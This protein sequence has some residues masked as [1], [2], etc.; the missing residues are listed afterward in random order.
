MDRTIDW[1]VLWGELVDLSRRRQQKRAT[2]DADRW[3]RRAEDF[4]SHVR[5]RW[6]RPDSSR[7][8]LVSTLDAMPG[9][10]LLDIGAGT[11]KWTV[12]LARHAKQVTAVEPSPAMFA[13]M[14]DNIAAAG[15]SNVVLV[16]EAW[17]HANAGLHDVT[18][19]S[20]S[21]YGFPDLAAVIA[22]IQAVTRRMCILLLR[23]PAVDGMMAEAAN[24]ILGHPYDSPNYHVAINVLLQMGI[25]PNVLMEYP[26]SWLPWSSDSLADALAEIKRRF[27]LDERNDHDDFLRDLLER[28]LVLSDG[29]YV[30]PQAMRTA[31]I[32]WPVDPESRP[33]F[34]YHVSLRTDTT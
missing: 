30:W 1:N 4:D 5:D 21:L 12:H 18:L 7:T 15:V 9:S 26:V 27:D 31:L 29:R 13:R 24:Q 22:S 16:Q 3:S 11:G 34:D 17:P 14:R 6:S 32:Y 8:F 2:G 23:A 33:R 10:T 19:C 20:H 25:F 28:R